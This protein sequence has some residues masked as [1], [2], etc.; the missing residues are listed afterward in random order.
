MCAP[1]AKDMGGGREV[2]AAVKVQLRRGQDRVKLENGKKGVRVEIR[3]GSQ[4]AR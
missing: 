2:K 4:Y 1:P 3:A